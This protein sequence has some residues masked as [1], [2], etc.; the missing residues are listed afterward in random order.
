[1]R[2]QSTA[3]E[4]AEQVAIYIAS[5]NAADPAGAGQGPATAF[6]TGLVYC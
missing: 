3:R 2:D 6:V 4:I 5:I 1:M